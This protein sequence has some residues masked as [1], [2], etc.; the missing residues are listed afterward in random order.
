MI[1]TY[2]P[3]LLFIFALALSGCSIDV[4]QP[5]AP[6][7]S[8]EFGPIAP[9]LPVGT[10][11]GPP[12]VA[13]TTIPVTWAG[14]NLTGSLVYASASLT[15]ITPIN[16]QSLDLITGEIKTIFTTTGDAWV[17]YMTIS[18][19][20]RQLVMSY[21]PPSVG[22]AL[23]SRA[24][25]RMP[26][27]GTTPPQLLFQPPTPDD[28]YIHVEWSP[29]GKYIYYVHYNNKDR[30]QPYPAYEMFRMAYPDSQPE[31]VADKAFWPR[32]SADSTTLVYVSL[33]PTSGV[34]ELFLANADGS[35]P[36]KITLS[37]PSIP[38]IIDAPIFSPDGASIL[39]SAPPPPQAYQPNW[40]EKLMGIQAA[41][42][43]SIP[44]DWWS[45]PVTG[46]ELTRLTQI[47][48]I[49]LFASISPDKNR[50]ASLSG[51]GLFV[52]NW[53]GSNLTQLL[54]NPGVSGT[55]SWIP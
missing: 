36:Q 23:S 35:N 31:K 3:R 55:V 14:L 45:V 49:N 13:S 24:L 48:T 33:D 4:A 16:I 40:F 50:I 52:M 11:N 47:Q 22:T 30:Q 37:G 27:D 6:T 28:H 46:G 8:L 53:D 5:V 44:S 42:A 32:I 39:F 29:D 43:H 51:E 7:P 26:V 20:G 9:T 18:P 19:D 38:G 10:D 17:Y 21:A 2:L 34:N 12:S 41:K 15:D 1:K 25:Y 54:F